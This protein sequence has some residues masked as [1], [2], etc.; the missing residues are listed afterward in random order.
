MSVDSTDATGTAADIT[1][2]ARLPD[3]EKREHGGKSMVNT[4]P[5]SAPF[6]RG[7]QRI[8]IQ[9]LN[10]ADS[11]R[12]AGENAE[13]VLLL[14]EAPAELPP[15]LVHRRTMRVIDGMHRLRA[16]QVRGDDTIG[17]RFFDGDDEVAF[18][19]AVE[20]NVTHGLPLTLTERKAAARRIVLSHADWADRAIASVTGLSA[21]T[22]SA[23]RRTTAADDR[24]SGARRVGVDGRIR[25]LDAAEGRRRAAQL[26]REQADAPLREI[27][28]RAGISVS[29]AKDVRD[30]VRRG[31]DP[32]PPG[33]HRR[34]RSH[35]V[36]EDQAPP[37]PGGDTGAVVGRS[38][39]ATLTILRN[40][41]TVRFTESGR[42]L[43]RWLATRSVRDDDWSGLLDVVQ[44]HT[45]RLAEDLARQHAASWTRFAEELAHRSTMER[46]AVV[47]NQRVDGR[48]TRGRAS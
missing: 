14:A 38:L 7:V 46:P 5:T 37:S 15:I 29:T 36:N 11:P 42:A 12:Q 48:S 25:P 2:I 34:S 47:P 18:R 13:H 32:V 27:A 28:R 40:D 9:R 10:P 19:L 16:A 23:I 41:P 3:G 4:F 8:P 39:E 24:V 35:T 17:A 45:A 6:E 1:S 44:P 30:R 20:A 43:L 26:I 21:K 22:V 31:D 33:R